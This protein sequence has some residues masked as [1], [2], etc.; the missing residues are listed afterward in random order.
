MNKYL[1]GLLFGFLSW[2]IPFISAFIFYSKEGKLTIPIDLFKSLL[3]VIG[4]LVGVFLL[5]IYFK[6]IKVNYLSE[7]VIVGISWFVVNIVLDLLILVPMSKM[8]LEGYANQ[9]GLRYLMIPI[10]STGIGCILQ[11]R[12]N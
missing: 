6:N 11:E 8:T 7:G 12:K 5:K 1:K 10:I 3:I 4:T 9:I 2:L